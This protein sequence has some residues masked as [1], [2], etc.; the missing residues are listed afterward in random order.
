MLIVLTVLLGAAAGL[1]ELELLFRKRRIG[2]AIVCGALSLAGIACA[3]AAASGKAFP[4]P[5]H[6]LMVVYGPFNRLMV[7]LFG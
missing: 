2:E 5:L 1:R 6:V 4:S 7:S 3:S